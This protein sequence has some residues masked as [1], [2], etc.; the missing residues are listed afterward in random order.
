VSINHESAPFLAAEEQQRGDNL[1]QVIDHFVS[2]PSTA[3]HDS[4]H[5]YQDAVQDAYGNAAR[6]TEQPERGQ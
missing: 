2:D 3:A 6:Y 4:L 5:L 1:A